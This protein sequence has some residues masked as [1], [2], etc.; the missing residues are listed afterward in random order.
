MQVPYL[1]LGNPTQAV[2]L[3]RHRSIR[4]RLSEQGQLQWECNYYQIVPCP[5]VT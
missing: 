3:R 5:Q 4:R 2:S 1:Y